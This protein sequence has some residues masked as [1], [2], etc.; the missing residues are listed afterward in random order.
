MEVDVR[1]QTMYELTIEKSFA[2]AHRLDAHPGVCKNLHGHTYRVRM[3]VRG[4]KLDATQGYL[5][6][7]G[8][9]KA[10]LSEE[11]DEYDHSFLND[12]VAFSDQPTTCENLARHLF[13]R[14]A[15]KVPGLASM[16]IYESPSAWVTYYPDEAD[17]A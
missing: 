5:T 1:K 4:T 12:L 16:T 15:P 3:V 10:L 6:D 11:L 17:C 2:A 7:F 13:D 9:L 14:L 8:Q